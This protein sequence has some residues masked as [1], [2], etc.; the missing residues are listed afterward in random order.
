MKENDTTFLSSQTDMLHSSPH[1]PPHVHNDASLCLLMGTMVLI[2]CRYDVG[3]ELYGPAV[4]CDTI[5]AVSYSGDLVPILD[6]N[7]NTPVPRRRNSTR[8]KHPQWRCPK[9]DGGK[10][11]R[12]IRK[13]PG[14]PML[15]P[16]NG[17]PLPECDLRLF[18]RWVED[19]APN[20]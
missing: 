10:P 1:K 15:M 12:G 5:V 17:N 20:N 6:L 9:F 8:V 4:D 7:C 2:G 18:E 19:G 16:K 14:D 11:A 3:D 13:S